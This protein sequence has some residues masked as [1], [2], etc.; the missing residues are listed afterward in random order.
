MVKESIDAF[1]KDDSALARKVLAND[2]LVDDLME[3]IFRE[4]LSYMIEDPHTIT[5]AIRLSFVAKYLER[6]ADHATNIAEL[7][8]YLVEGKII[9]HTTP[10]QSV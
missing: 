8:V 1:V 3:Q 10:A 7:V 6:I 4:L 9:R 5:R 2:D